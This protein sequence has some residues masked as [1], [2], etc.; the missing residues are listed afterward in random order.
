MRSFMPGSQSLETDEIVL[1][2]AGRFVAEKGVE[3][4]VRVLASVRAV[5]PARL[6]LIGDGPDKPA[7]LQIADSFGI[8]DY[9][10]FRPWMKS[11]D[12]A[13]AYRQAHFVL[14]P[15]RPT[16]RWVEQFGRV[17]IELRRAV[18]SWLGMQAV[19]SR[20]S[21]RR[22]NH[23]ADR[24]CARLAEAIINVLAD[25]P[26]FTRI[27]NAGLLRVSDFSWRSVAFTPARSL[28]S[29]RF[30]RRA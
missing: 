18:Q 22:G 16:T 17:I 14:I 2:F 24:R 30:Y 25:P 26:E 28:S 7:V 27:R 19:Q 3:D 4:A 6:I 20:C 15:S 9:V 23:C 1:M 10:E 12:L 13:S 5:R 11:A 29:R 21:W 8:T